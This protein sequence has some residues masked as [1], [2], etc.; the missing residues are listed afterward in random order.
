MDEVDSFQGNPEWC[1][2]Y[3]EDLTLSQMLQNLWLRRPI[4]ICN[5]QAPN[6]RYYRWVLSGFVTQS[7]G[8]STH[9]LPGNGAEQ[10][11]VKRRYFTNLLFTP[12]YLSYTGEMSKG[13]LQYFLTRFVKIQ[14]Q[15]QQRREKG[16]WNEAFL[17]FWGFMVVPS[18]FR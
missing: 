12:S 15:K 16:G 6:Y 5:N 11:R 17:R 8:S 4:S 7:I 10:G 13:K 18:L 2:H 3:L 1:T 14:A 9:L